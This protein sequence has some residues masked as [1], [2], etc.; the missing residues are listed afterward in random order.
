MTPDRCAL[1]GRDRPLTFHHLVPKKVHS[2]RRVKRRF[3]RE[4]LQR[5]IHLCR[6]CHRA[7]HHFVPHLELAERYHTLDAL[8]EHPD[9]AR[10]VAWASK[11]D[12]GKGYVR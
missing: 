6:P 8:R 12:R 10:F 4:E 7:V 3:D 2:R 1:C 11:Q 5:G 9:I